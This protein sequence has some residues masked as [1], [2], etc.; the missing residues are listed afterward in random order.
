M[1]AAAPAP[2]ADRGPRSLLASLQRQLEW[3]EG[4]GDNSVAYAIVAA[5]E[6]LRE[7]VKPRQLSFDSKWPADVP[8][9]DQGRTLE[10]LWTRVQEQTL[11][12]EQVLLEMRE[13]IQ[14]QRK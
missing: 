11:T 5:L 9:M 10:P 14:A 1:S 3:S 7:Q 2:A 13:I 4:D 6:D 12:C 8:F